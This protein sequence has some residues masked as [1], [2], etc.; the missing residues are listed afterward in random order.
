M[1]QPAK[2]PTPKGPELGSFPLDH[3]RECKTEVE[4]YYKCLEANNHVTPLC[5]EHVLKYLNC[6]MDRGLMNKMDVTKFGI[7][8]SNFVPT[9]THKEDTQRDALRAGGT[10]VQVQ[11]VWESKF[12]NP[13]L[14]R[15]DGFEVDKVT[16]ERIIDMAATQEA[17]AP[18]RSKGDVM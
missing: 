9:R 3:F 10:A 4:D 14:Q 2:R 13:E 6:R 18:S 17:H 1:A 15:D 8:D 11:A 12:K 16:G 5:R 7:P